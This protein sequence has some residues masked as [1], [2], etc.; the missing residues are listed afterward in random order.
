MFNSFHFYSTDADSHSNVVDDFKLNHQDCMGLEEICIGFSDVD[1][2]F[3]VAANL[4]TDLSIM[5]CDGASI[6]SPYLDELLEAYN[7]DDK[8]DKPSIAFTDKIVEI[9]SRDHPKGAKYG[10]PVSIRRA[11]QMRCYDWTRPT[12][13]CGYIASFQALARAEARNDIVSNNVSEE[14]MSML[15]NIIQDSNLSLASEKGRDQ[16]IAVIDSMA[17]SIDVQ[18]AK[19]SCQYHSSEM[20]ALENFRNNELKSLKVWIMDN[21][22]GG[23]S[24]KGFEPILPRDLWFDGKFLPFCFHSD[25][26]NMTV[27]T[28]NPSGKSNSHYGYASM[29]S[30]QDF[31]LDHGT[32][33]VA[34]FRDVIIQKHMN[35]FAY[36]GS[37]FWALPSGN[38]CHEQKRLDSAIRSCAYSIE[39]HLFKRFLVKRK[40]YRLHLNVKM[41]STGNES[42]QF[43][44]PSSLRVFELSDREFSIDYT[45]PDRSY[46]LYGRFNLP[47]EN[48]LI[49]HVLHFF[50]AC[51]V[52]PL[53]T[54]SSA[55]YIELC[56]GNVITLLNIE[57]CIMFIERDVDCLPDAKRPNLTFYLVRSDN[58]L[59]IID[60]DP[61]EE[62]KRLVALLLQQFQSGRLSLT[63]WQPGSTTEIVENSVV[64]CD[65]WIKKKKKVTFITEHA[66][67]KMKALLLMLS[68]GLVSLLHS[69]RLVL[70][71]L[72]EL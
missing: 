36:D 49:E 24:F 58:I 27:F 44:F 34:T 66:L 68:V 19:N 46:A 28:I 53:S 8:Y 12:G 15:D 37:H 21:S 41:E 2:R 13:P 60:E 3:S 18:L 10:P 11:V 64:N 56:I 22:Y 57:Y 63:I 30:N 1:K 17:E 25:D 26:V 20:V 55:P 48:C 71:N 33:D 47:Q 5:V 51:L 40:A 23:K 38:E 9:L 50:P 59:S 39:E 65:T 6:T 52:A 45:S 61:D 54:I 43:S 29:F 4:F 69:K 67:K 35:Y 7:D 31:L 42:N 14:Q 62:K 72:S 16:F 70:E 32:V